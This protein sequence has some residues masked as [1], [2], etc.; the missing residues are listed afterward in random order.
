[1]S[2]STVVYRIKIFLLFAI[3][4]PPLPPPHSSSFFLHFG[5]PRQERFRF[6]HIGLFIPRAT[7]VLMDISIFPSPPL[8]LL[9]LLPPFNYVTSPFLFQN[10]HFPA[11][12][13]TPDTRNNYN[14]NYIIDISPS[15][16]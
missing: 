15:L 5:K 10:P 16:R 6:N 2:P 14:I 9:S 13:R 3:P 4:P 12:G 7:F 1:M 8:P 11:R